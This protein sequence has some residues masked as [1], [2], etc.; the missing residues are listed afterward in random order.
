MEKIGKSGC[1]G[2]LDDK[3]GLSAAK[4]KIPAS[5]WYGLILLAYASLLLLFC[6][7]NSPLFA[8]QEWIDPNIYMDVGKAVRKGLVLYRDVFDHKGPLLLLVFAVLSIPSQYSMIGLYLLLCL[9]LGISLIYLFRTARLFVPEKTSLG[10]CLVFPFFLLNNLTY[11]Q[12]GGS[13]EELLLPCFCGSL[14]YLVRFFLREK[15]G[16]TDRAG[17]RELARPFFLLGIFAGI[18]L[19]VKINLTAF[20]LALCGL[21]FLRMLFRKQFVLFLKT[22]GIF[23]GGISTACLPAAVYLAAT[24]SFRDFFDAYILFNLK[25]AGHP[26]DTAN[27]LSFPDALSTGLFLNLAALLVTAAGIAVL[28]WRAK[29]MSVFGSIALVLGY[30]ALLVAIYISR[31]AYQYEYIPLTA[32][33]GIGEIGVWFGLTEFWANRPPE[34]ARLRMPSAVKKFLIIVPFLVIVA[35]NEL[36]KDTIFLRPGVTGVERIA[37]VIKDGRQSDS[38]VDQ[39]NILLYNSGDQGFFQLTGCSPELRIFYMPMMNYQVYPD[40]VNAQDEYVTKGLPDYIITVWYDD[41]FIYP[42]SEMNPAYKIIDR[43]EQ[44]IEGAH[45]Y[46]TLFGKE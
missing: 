42:I 31:R 1:T 37:A 15:Q 40:L 10:I 9:T 44:E 11:S 25:Y 45:V 41:E 29:R 18:V 8:Y 16:G 46:L 12:G 21:V 34:L 4:G 35:S 3:P 2:T 38:S 5:F 6:T 39:P 19:L 23:L 13:A 14:F 20:F 7:R 17:F 32:F 33:A 24:N 26:Y 30:A 22:A 28:A 36:Y 43:E 27:L